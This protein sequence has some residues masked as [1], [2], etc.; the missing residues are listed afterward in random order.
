MLKNNLLQKISSIYENKNTQLIINL[1]CIFILVKF[2]FL[3]LNTV[4]SVFSYTLYH[5]TD[6]KAQEKVVGNNL[7]LHSILLYIP[8]FL[9]VIAIFVKKVQL[10]HFIF[11]LL[12]AHIALK[13]QWFDILHNIIKDT[14]IFDSIRAK[15]RTIINNQY[16]RIICYLTVIIILFSQVLIKKYRSLSRIFILLI[17]VSCLTT[18]TIFHVAVPMGMFKYIVLDKTQLAQYDI[19]NRNK[20]DVCKFKNCYYLYEN[21]KAEI[22]TQRQKVDNLDSYNWVISKS[23]HHMKSNNT[24]VYSEAVSVNSG[25]LFDY[26]IIT[27]KKESDK[28]FTTIDTTT[29]RKFSRESEIMFSFLAIMA[30]FTWIIGGLMLLEFH[31]YKF[32]KRVE[33]NIIKEKK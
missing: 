33:N 25:F 21:G 3:F 13:Y 17:T 12:L 2:I 9:S 19:E 31:Y 24:N 10:K 32:K 28:Y 27:M 18:I 5:H 16:T 30:H 6:L 8:I 23:I 11:S 4:T 7:F 26:D 29:L 14:F 22:I 20:N 15:G 1:V